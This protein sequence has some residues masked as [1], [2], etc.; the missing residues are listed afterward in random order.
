VL[1]KSSTSVT[2]RVYNSKG[3]L[4]RESTFASSYVGDKAIIH[5]GTKKK[6]KPKPKPKAVTPSDY[7]P[8][9]LVP[10]DTTPAAAAKT[11]TTT[12]ATTG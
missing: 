4:L 3:A 9:D 8:E 1:S 5:V 11:P 7:L 12:P 10:A 2:R 6:P